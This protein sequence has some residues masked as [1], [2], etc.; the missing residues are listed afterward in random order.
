LFINNNL[1]TVVFFGDAL[2]SETVWPA[3]ENILSDSEK[4]AEMQE[5]LAV[6]AS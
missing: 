1:F 2:R 3:L 5:C 4:V 6:I